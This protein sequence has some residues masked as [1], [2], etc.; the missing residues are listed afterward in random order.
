MPFKLL[1]RQFFPLPI[2]RKQQWILPAFTANIHN[3]HL[4]KKLQAV[5]K[6]RVQP[7]CRHVD[8]A[9]HKIRANKIPKSG[10][11]TELVH[12]NKN[13]EY[14]VYSNVQK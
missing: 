5:R 4:H 14:S 3:K 10:N 8:I 12:S 13:I 7:S 2:L 1:R 6:G 11:K 9:I